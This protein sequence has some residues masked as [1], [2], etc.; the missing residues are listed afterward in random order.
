MWLFMLA[1]PIGLLTMIHLV[2]LF[3]FFISF[4]TVGFQ[5]ITLSMV[6]GI[7]LFFGAVSPLTFD[8]LTY[9]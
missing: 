7:L 8:A 9:S 2:F 6:G 5:P 4:I 3:A 1:V